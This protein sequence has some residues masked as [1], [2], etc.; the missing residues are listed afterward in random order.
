M[1]SPSTSFVVTCHNLGAY[2]EEALDSLFAQTAQDF[3][4]IVVNDG[5]TDGATCRLLAT[6]DRPRTRVVHSERL[7]LPGARNLGARHAAGRYLCMVDA[8]DLL[9]PAYLERSVQVLESRP[10]IAFASHWLRAF[11]DQAW[12]WTPTD[13][14]FP[15]L[16]HANT[17]NGAALL[18]RDVFEQ[19]GGFD[20]TM[21]DGCEDWEFWIR[22]IEAGFAGVI[23]PEFLFR[24]RRRADSMSRAMHA[25]PGMPALYRQLVE[26]HPDVFARHMASLLAHRDGEIASLSTSL[27][28]LDQ[29]WAADLSGRLQW[30]EDNRAQV[31]RAERSAPT[32]ATARLIEAATAEA[33]T[34]H[35][36]FNHEKQQHEAIRASWSWRITAP[37]RA[38]LDLVRR[39]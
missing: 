3:E 38:V 20:E 26:R 31:E 35:A 23:I 15:A 12:D 8:D 14:T 17:L 1:A 39:R 37:L 9:E 36:A 22:V 5:S 16:L 34:F 11:G 2:L 18:R 25:V 10:D 29:Y 4:V 28:R 33:R 24:Y 7:G 13:C 32:A 6:L 21:R 19:V 27:W 30:L